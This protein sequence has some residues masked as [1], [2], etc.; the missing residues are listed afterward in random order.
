DCAD[1]QHAGT[2]NAGDQHSVGPRKCRQLRQRHIFE[3][4][5][6]RSDGGGVAPSKGAAADAHEARTESCDTAQIAIAARLVDRALAS[7]F[8]VE[9]LDSDAVRLLRAVAAT[10]AD[11]GV[12]HDALNRLRLDAPL[13]PAALL[14]R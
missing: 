8:G 11:C 1:G 9:R 6:A 12:D 5:I 3:C 14:G 7:E 10:F 4:A 13:A 2:A